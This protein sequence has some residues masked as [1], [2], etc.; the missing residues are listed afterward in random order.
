MYSFTEDDIER[1]SHLARIK[2]TDEGRKKLRENLEKVV[3]YIEQLAEVPTENVPLCVHVNDHIQTVCRA[4]EIKHDLTR[5]AFLAN[6]PDQVGGM[7]KTPPVIKF[8]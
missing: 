1:L 8:E 2:I 5:E 6:A 3:R 4:D 7:I